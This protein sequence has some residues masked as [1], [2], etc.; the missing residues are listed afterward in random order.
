MMYADRRPDARAGLQLRRASAWLQC[1]ALAACALL[2]ACGGGGGGGGS[3]S[4]SPVP[5]ASA[6]NSATTPVIV[7]I[8]ANPTAL[9]VGESATLTWSSSNATS[10]QAGDAWSG[11]V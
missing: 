11:A 1:A 5:T 2:V 4:T 6:T 8:G 10:C 3:S 7:S 9:T